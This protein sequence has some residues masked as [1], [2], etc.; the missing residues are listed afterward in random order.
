MTGI[1]Q[2]PNHT[3]SI[4]LFISSGVIQTTCPFPIQLYILYLFIHGMSADSNLRIIGLLNLL[5]HLGASNQL[6]LF[7]TIHC[8]LTDTY[9][10]SI[11]RSWNV[12]ITCTPLFYFYSVLSSRCI[13][14]SVIGICFL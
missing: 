3:Y 4:I 8:F 12:Q 6:L 10:I 14:I 7:W 11:G 5:E 13:R 9:F 1:L 2:C